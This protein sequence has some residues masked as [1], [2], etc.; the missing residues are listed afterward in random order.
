MADPVFRNKT[1]ENVY[2][3]LHG[4][5]GQT[6]S[7]HNIHINTHL[8]ERTVRSSLTALKNRGLVVPDS[9]TSNVWSIK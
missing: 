6:A 8:P 5:L 2:L 9:E 4:L 7:V 3:Y 1:H